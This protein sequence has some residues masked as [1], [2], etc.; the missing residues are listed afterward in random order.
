MPDEIGTETTRPDAPSADDA[1]FGDA[2][3]KVDDTPA[4]VVEKEDGKGDT[5][6]DAQGAAG[7]GDKPDA[8]VETEAAE[9]LKVVVSSRAVGPSSGCNSPRRTRT[10]RPSMMPT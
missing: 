1:L 6:Q 5:E 8:E 2:A 9:E 3:D 7:D 10:L 4:A